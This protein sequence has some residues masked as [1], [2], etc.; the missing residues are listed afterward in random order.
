MQP[1]KPV[2]REN[3]GFAAEDSEKASETDNEPDSE[4]IAEGQESEADD[5]VDFSWP[6]RDVT[7]GQVF[8]RGVADISI[9]YEEYNGP[10]KVTGIFW[11]GV[12][13]EV[14]GENEPQKVKIGYGEPFYLSLE[15]VTEMAGY[16]R[17]PMEFVK[18]DTGV[19]MVPSC[20]GGTVHFAVFSGSETWG[21]KYP[22][23][24]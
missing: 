13:L 19:K 17:F 7:E 12:E 15:F 24:D 20:K 14:V 4:P 18:S 16:T 23:C 6:E 10:S 9:D 8:G 1:L 22:F 21:E 11:D 2:P 3:R 5:E